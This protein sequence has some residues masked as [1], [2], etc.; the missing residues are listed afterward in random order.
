MIDELIPDLADPDLRAL[1]D[2]LRGRREPR[3]DEKCVLIAVG[4][5]MAGAVL[6][7]TMDALNE[8][9]KETY[10]KIALLIERAD[11]IDASGVAARF[12]SYIRD[13]DRE[14][15]REAGGG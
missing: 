14:V 1:Y 10:A 6:P 4:A 2:A 13:V 7:A 15:A 8:F 9:G 12:I 3:M 11:R 5:R